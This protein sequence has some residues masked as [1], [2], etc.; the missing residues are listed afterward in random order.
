MPQDSDRAIVV[1]INRYLKFGGDG[2][3]AQNLAGP[4]YDAKQM[5]NWLTK[6]AKVHVTLI[7]SD[8]KPKSKWKVTDLRP[9]SSD[10]LQELN[11]IIGDGLRQSAANQSGRLGRRL[12]IYMAGH[13]FA[14]QPRTLSLITAEALGDLSLPNIEATAWADWFADQLFFDEIVLWMDC[15][16]TRAFQYPS[17]KPL[18]KSVAARQAGRAKLFMG[19]ASRPSAFAYE[20]PVGKKG[21]VRG[22]FTARLLKGLDGA[23]ADSSGVV[24]TRGLISYLENTSGVVGDEAV[25]TSGEHVR[26]EPS[27][28]ER[29]DLIFSTATLP[30][31][32]LK[33]PVADG[34]SV[35]ILDGTYQKVMS[36]VVT[37]ASRA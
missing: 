25:T 7:T 32:H 24:R 1:G 12:Y 34:Q 36:V 20:A 27:F 21:Q 23:A 19:F 10:I 37:G 6:S 4:V 31:Y 5:A 9:E 11:A 13:G 33:I 16:A 35:D 14:P 30:E 3:S 29:D 8:G 15:C 28:P 18:I 2:V 22:L 17:G 26:L